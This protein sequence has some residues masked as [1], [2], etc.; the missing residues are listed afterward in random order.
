MESE[1]ASAHKREKYGEG[2]GGASIRKHSRQ[3]ERERRLQRSLA[4]TYSLIDQQTY[5]IAYYNQ[6]HTHQIPQKKIRK[7][8]N[9]KHTKRNPCER[10]EKNLLKSLTEVIVID[11][12][13]SKP[14]AYFPLAM[15]A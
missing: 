11:F 7:K 12:V 2:N 3:R 6:T 4:L 15:F 10:M 13:I 5:Y 9:P 14:V 1:L 8:S